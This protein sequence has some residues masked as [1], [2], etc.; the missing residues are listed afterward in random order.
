M[1]TIDCA[2]GIKDADLKRSTLTV[3][4]NPASNQISFTNDFA[5]STTA[6]VRITDVTGRTVKAI[7]LG[8][9][10][11]GS[12]TFDIDI[13]DLNNGMYY[14]ELVTESNRSISKF[15]KK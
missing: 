10:N 6:T 9:Q 8:K 11:T 2:V 7:D 1:L 12:R 3:Y 4:P 15:T 14:I 13:N 5:A